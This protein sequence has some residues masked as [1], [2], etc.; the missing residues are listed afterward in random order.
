MEPVGRLVAVGLVALLGVAGSSESG[1][2]QAGDPDA[3][4]QTLLGDR[5]DAADSADRSLVRIEVSPSTS[6]TPV[7][8]ASAT[9]RATPAA[10]QPEPVAGL[11]RAQMNNAQIIVHVGQ[12]MGFP[13]KGLIIAVATAMQE[14]DLY[15]LASRAV[16][17]SFDYPHQGDSADH[18]SC[19]LFQQRASMGWGTV[20]QIMTP[21]YSAGK[22]YSALR[23]IEGWQGME[24]TLAA[25]AVQRSA[26]PYAY[27]K[28]ESRATT[29]V[30]ALM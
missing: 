28:H 2:T 6:P 5:A 27:A 18:D 10:A 24:V 25:Q 9:A 22:F 12:K 20:Q 16:P 29:I 1:H 26:Y 7:A 13:R 30:D 17:E 21:S 4:A 23:E 11:D 8:V 14:S 3:S 15:N 19:G